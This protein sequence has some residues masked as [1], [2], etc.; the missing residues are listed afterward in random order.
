MS[1][2]L[3]SMKFQGKEPHWPQL[4][5]MSTAGPNVGGQEDAEFPLTVLGHGLIP[6]A[7]GGVRISLAMTVSSR[8]LVPHEKLGC[9]FQNE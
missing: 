4:C 2:P 1:F 7:K 5:H 9:Y 3:V 8:E 6:V